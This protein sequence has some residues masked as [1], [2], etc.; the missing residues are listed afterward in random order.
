MKSQR[1]ARLKIA[2]LEMVDSCCMNESKMRVS[3]G[4]FQLRVARSFFCDDLFAE[5]YSNEKS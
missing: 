4:G 1:G 5:E 2:L 3:F